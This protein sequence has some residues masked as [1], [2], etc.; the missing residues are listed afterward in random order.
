[1]NIV[2]S[3]DELPIFN[4][5]DLD[6]IDVL[7]LVKCLEDTSCLLIKASSIFDNKAN[8]Q[9]I[10]MMERY[11]NQ[12]NDVKSKDVRIQSNYQVGYTPEFLENSRC[13]GDI[14]CKQIIS[15]QSHDNK[16]HQPIDKDPKCRFM[17]AIGSRPLHSA[18]T[19]LNASSTRAVQTRMADNDGYCR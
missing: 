3:M 11:F 4:L 10:D 9:F 16:A 8:L 6:S 1:M 13:I 19:D 12:P 14:N 17:W 5:D 7:Q 2:V 15:E 18:Y